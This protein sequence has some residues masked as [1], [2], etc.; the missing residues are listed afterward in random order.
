MEHRLIA[1]DVLGR[2]LERTEVVH[3]INGRRAD[4][5]PEN[6]CVMDRLDHDGYHCWYD[7]I[8]KTYGRYPRRET[9]LRKLRTTFRGTLLADVLAKGK[10][11]G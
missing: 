10:R 3:H 9:Q 8:F 1:E 5:S 2:R 6:L 7:W 4:N 11:S